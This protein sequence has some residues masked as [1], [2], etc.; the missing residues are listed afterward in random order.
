MKNFEIL[1]I[2]S[3]L[4]IIYSKVLKTKKTGCIGLGK[5]CDL[6][7]WCCGSGVC[8]D[9]RCRAKGTKDNQEKW[10]ND[11]KNPGKKCDWFHHCPD[12]YTCASHRCVLSEKF[13]KSISSNLTNS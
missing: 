7:S 11:K 2:I 3:L 13:L 8:K 6:F 12:N 9:Y 5:D 10:A 4:I 1:I